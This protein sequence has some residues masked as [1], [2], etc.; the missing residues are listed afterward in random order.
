MDVRVKHHDIQEKKAHTERGV[1]APKTPSSWAWIQ[2]Q[3]HK[4]TVPLD[5]EIWGAARPPT[6]P[7]PSQEGWQN[8]APAR[9]TQVPCQV[10]ETVTAV[11][12]QC[13]HGV[14]RAWKATGGA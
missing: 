8:T 5:K 10:V 7:V 14:P 3:L 9:G 2:K 1:T 11:W 13:P 4:A 12:V 6:K